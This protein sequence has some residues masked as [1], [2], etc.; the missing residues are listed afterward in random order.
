M[1]ELTYSTTLKA[2]GK[3]Y[4]RIVFWNRFLRNPIELILSWIPAVISIILMSM[5][6]IT[7]FTAILYAACWFYPI[8][9]F[10]FQ[11]RHSV[12]YHLKHRDPSEAAPCT[13]S[14]TDDCILADI[15]SFEVVET[16]R[17]DEFTT[18][19]KKLGYYMLFSGSKMIVML[20]IA[21]MSE[22]Q[23]KAIPEYIKNHI[24]MNKC[25]VLF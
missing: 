20:R 4:E 10:A 24:N 7:S 14:F 9:I 19:Y 11:F 5:G 23:Q 25:K 2:C 17:W 13:I 12:A 3:E 1:K 15:P 6:Y 21:D 8:Y 18:I 22:D 16:Y